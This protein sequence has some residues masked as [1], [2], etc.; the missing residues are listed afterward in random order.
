[1]SL[2]TIEVKDTA[3]F[4]SIIKTIITMVKDTSVANRSADCFNCRALDITARLEKVAIGLGK[5][6]P[7]ESK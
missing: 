4:E 5:K 1:M 3:E 7:E 2:L 6:L